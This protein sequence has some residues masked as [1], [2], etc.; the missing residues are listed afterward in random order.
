MIYDLQNLQS[1]VGK[2]I[3]ICS[4]SMSLLKALGAIKMD[5]KRTLCNM[6]ATIKVIFIWVPGQ[7]GVLARQDSDANLMGPEPATGY[8]ISTI[9][10][11]LH[12]FALPSERQR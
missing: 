10:R 7:T 9:I 1:A 5:R 4:N 8:S 3:A 2:S 12:Y 11:D 6:S